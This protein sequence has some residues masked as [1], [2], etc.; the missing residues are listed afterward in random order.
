MI[1][2]IFIVRI[3]C[4]LRKMLYYLFLGSVQQIQIAINKHDASKNKH[5]ASKLS[6]NF[7]LELVM[8]KKIVPFKKKLSKRLVKVISGVA[9]S[10]AASASQAIFIETAVFCPANNV[11]HAKAHLYLTQYEYLPSDLGVFLFVGGNAP[12][13]DDSMGDTLP[14]GSW[15]SINSISSPTPRYTRKEPTSLSTMSV[16]FYPGSVSSNSIQKTISD[17]VPSNAGPSWP[18]YIDM[19]ECEIKVTYF[20][21]RYDY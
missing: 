20:G 16:I 4:P 9:L 14:A 8:N 18:L 19:P 3:A 6:L 5:D 13:A 15:Y 17:I 2:D 12:G 21:G 11:T 1:I 7:F 10:L